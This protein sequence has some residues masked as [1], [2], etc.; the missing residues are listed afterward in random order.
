MA[1]VLRDFLTG[2]TIIVVGMLLSLA[3]SLV[4]LFLWIFLHLVG[5]LAW[6]FFFVFLVFFSVWLIG[7]VYRK[8][9]EMGNK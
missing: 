6:V 5:A 2:S 9:R 7:Y 3:A 8:F 1:H 4:L